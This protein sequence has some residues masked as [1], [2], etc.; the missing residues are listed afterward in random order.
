MRSCKRFAM[1]VA[2]ALPCLVLALGMAAGQRKSNGAKPARAPA[3]AAKSQAPKS[4]T[5]PAGAVEVEPGIFQHTD[6]KG[7]VWL[8]RRTPFGIAKYEPESAVETA[9]SGEGLLASAEGDSVRFERKTP[10]GVTR[11]T[12]KK[13]ELNA[14]ESAAWKRVSPPEAASSSQAQGSPARGKE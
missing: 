14:E 13:S 6:G 7:K 5:I 2:V 10:F 1:K 11:W 9:P 8:Y 3:A 12:K 4:T